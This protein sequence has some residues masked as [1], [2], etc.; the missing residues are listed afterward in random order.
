M[1]CPPRRSSAG[2][3]FTLLELIVV[4]VILSI[5][6]AMAWPSM[7]K[8]YVRGEI[9]DAAKQVR[10]ALVRTRLKAIE[11]G[12]TQVFRFQ[13]GTGRFEVVAKSVA[14]GQADPT[15]MVLDETG[16]GD[17]LGSSADFSGY[18]ISDPLHGEPTWEML[19][20]KIRFAGQDLDDRM[21]AQVNAS[22]NA[23]P[24]ESALATPADQDFSRS[25]LQG[26]PLLDADPLIGLDPVSSLGGM[27]GEEEWSVPIVFYPNGRSSNARIR[28]TDQGEYYVD[29]SLRGLT[30][31]ARIGKIRRWQ[32]QTQE[33]VSLEVIQ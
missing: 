4:V 13:P 23:N 14:D 28:L 12:T 26:N 5:V 8:M 31:G 18:A 25:G 11:T 3:G 10:E 24:L 20:Y 32:E 19:G 30:G 27:S 15:V 9:E 7:R 1:T 29:V 16:L 6:A 33:E 21:M 2:R 17:P 22:E